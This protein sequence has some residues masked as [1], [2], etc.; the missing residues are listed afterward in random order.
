M[1][2]VDHNSSDTSPSS[3][4]RLCHVHT[5]RRTE[6]TA[7]E[8]DDHSNLDTS[9][10]ILSSRAKRMARKARVEADLLTQ[11]HDLFRNSA[12]ESVTE[13]ASRPLPLPTKNLRQLTPLGPHVH[14]MPKSN[15]RQ[16]SRLK[17]LVHLLP[18]KKTFASYR[19]WSRVSTLG[20]KI[21]FA[22]HRCRSRMS[23]AC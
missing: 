6:H 14:R 7:M 21:P 1:D 2:D 4:P 10:S 9:H 13:G 20:R 19:S 17:P 5:R 18:N 15:R 12:D 23:T 8:D 22:S 11:L 16:I 3:L